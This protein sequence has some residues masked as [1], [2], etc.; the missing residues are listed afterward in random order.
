M[1]NLEQIRARN[2]LDAYPK[3]GKGEEGGKFLDSFPAMIIENGLLATIAF[4]KAKKK[5]Y[6]DTCDAIAVHLKSVG[7]SHLDKPDASSLLDWLT[8]Q[9]SSV[10]R[11][12]TAETLAYLNYL[13]RFKKS[14]EKED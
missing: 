6:L 7:T 8:K 9:E 3:I 4:S 5:G 10:L 12:C 11:M 1:K 14:A 13:R 2:A